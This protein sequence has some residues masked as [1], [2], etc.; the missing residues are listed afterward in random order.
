M[1]ETNGTSIRIEE[2]LNEII[3][4]AT[5]DLDSPLRKLGTFIKRLEETI[6]PGN[7]DADAYMK[8]INAC[9]EEMRAIVS[10]LIELE[11]VSGSNGYVSCNMAAVVNKVK[12]DLRE[13]ME[14]KKATIRLSSL[15]ELPFDKEQC[16]LLY[17]KLIENSLKFAKPGKPLEI[18]IDG[19]KLGTEELKARGLN[20]N[21]GYRVIVEDNGIGFDEE[22]AEQI[23][24]PFQ[25]LHGKSAYPGS[26]L[27]LTIVKRIVENHQGKIF[28]EGK[29]NAGSRFILLIPENQ[30]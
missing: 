17:R 1:E 7:V 13:K 16:Y 27:G 30:H 11:A 29:G 6:P 19:E 23:F 24:E 21:N 20:S 3:A 26:G 2:R 5:H 18:S 4:L 12:Q 28:A 10:S 15:P 22:D 9:L 14:E 25:R 8:R